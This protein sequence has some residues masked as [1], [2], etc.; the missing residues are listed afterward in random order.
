MRQ[1]RAVRYDVD[2]RTLGDPI[3]RKFAAPWQLGSTWRRSV[4]EFASHEWGF[5]VEGLDSLPRE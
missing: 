1:I 2:N 4:R 5:R 3:S